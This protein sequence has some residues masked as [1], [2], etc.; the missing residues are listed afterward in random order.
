MVKYYMIAVF[1]CMMS[2]FSQILLKKS[3][4]KEKTAKWKEYLNI[5]VIMGYAILVSCMLLTVL[6]YRGL[7][8]KY[9]A[10]LE[11]L[12]Y[13]YVMILSRIF[14]GEKLTKKK[15]AGNI[16]IVVGVIVFSLGK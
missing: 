16:I 5:Y 3:A 7:P 6:A 2:S 15:V 10:I 11:S 9:G 14:L 13:L 12:G 4:E 1:S 8:F